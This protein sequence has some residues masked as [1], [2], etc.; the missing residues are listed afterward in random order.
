MK[1]TYYGHAC[2]GVQVAGK[3]L[4]FDPFI[5]PNELARA[6]DVTKVPADFIMVSTGTWITWP[7]R[8]T[9]PY[10][11]ATIVSNTK[12]QFG[13]ANRAPKPIR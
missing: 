4:L 10:R 2:F 11:C 13:W 5:T 3:A 6:V 8:L 1:V 9:L 12:S 7:T